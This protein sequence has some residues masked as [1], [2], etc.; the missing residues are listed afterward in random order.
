[1]ILYDA[2]TTG[3]SKVLARLHE[4][5]PSIVAS[6]RNLAH[7]LLDNHIYRRQFLTD[8]FEERSGGGV[9]ILGVRSGM[10]FRSGRVGSDRAGQMNRVDG[11]DSDYPKI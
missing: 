2:A 8:G 1:M 9:H 3:L 7:T 4:L 10:G 5:T 6:S 11:N